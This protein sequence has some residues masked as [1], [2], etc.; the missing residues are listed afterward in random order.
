MKNHP[1]IKVC[2]LTQVKQALICADLGVDAIGLVFFAKSPRYLT[3]K[4][5]A[6][7]CGA[8][9]ANITKVGVFVNESFENIMEHVEY[10]GLDAVQLHGNE[11]NALICRLQ[12]QKNQK[13]QKNQKDQKIKI[14]K[15]LFDGR[16]P[17]LKTASSYSADAYLV[18]CGKGEQPGGNALEWDWGAAK[19]LT[20]RQPLI[21][22][23]G[24]RP[25]NVS[26]AI[27]AS[28][29]HAVD[30]SSGVEEKPGI[31]DLAKVKAFVKAVKNTQT[32]SKKLIE[33]EFFNVSPFEH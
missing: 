12:K 25:D 28:L 27:L 9:A 23:G 13:G 8:V 19:K 11:S 17:D 3:K 6:L 33:G 10:C 26:Q 1:Q 14:I 4:Q 16:R 15:A 2:G 5:A 20:T 31:K 18:E 7:I 32:Q 29:P 22:A 30:V 24:L 21:I